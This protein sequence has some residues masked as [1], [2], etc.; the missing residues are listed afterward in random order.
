MDRIRTHLDHKIVIAHNA[1]FDI[2][3]LR[4]MLNEYGLAYPSFRYAC[5]VDIAKRVW[6]DL[7]NYKLSTLAERF[8][9]QFDHHNAL[10][11]ARTCARI[12]LLAQ[13]TIKAESFLDLTEKLQVKVKQF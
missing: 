7:D 13:Q 1:V 9:I 2:S 5:T 4:S 6:K 12:A 10:H 3:V 11:D 8:A